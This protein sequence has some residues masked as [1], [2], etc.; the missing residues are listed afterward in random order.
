MHAGFG[1]VHVVLLFQFLRLVLPNAGFRRHGRLFGRE[2]ELVRIIGGERALH[3]A[4]GPEPLP[5]VVLKQREL[6]RNGA[7]SCSKRLRRRRRRR[8]R[9]RHRPHHSPHNA[10]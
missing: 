9:L 8:R 1:L 10:F 4:L 3:E 2:A 6:S 5:R 7:R